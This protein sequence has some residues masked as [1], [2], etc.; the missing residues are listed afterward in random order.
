MATIKGCH[1]VGSVPL[2]DT[3]TV[4]KTCTQAMPNRLKRLPDGETGARQHFIACQGLL[5]PPAVQ[6]AF[7]LNKLPEF[8]DFSPE[9][10]DEGL[11]LL[12]KADMKTGYDDAAL[13]SYAVFRQLKQ[14]GVIPADVRFQVSLPALGSVVSVFVQKAFQPRAE[15]LYEAAMFDAM[16]NIQEGIPHG[17]LAIQ[18]D[19]AVDMFHWEGAWGDPWWGDREHLVGYVARM[20]DQVDKD[21]ELGFH[22]CYGEIILH[23]RGDDVGELTDVQLQATWTTGTSSNHSRSR[24]SP[25]SA[26]PSSTRPTARRPLCT[27]PCP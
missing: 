8:R 27:A 3:E 20:A 13:A 17:E 24:A 19:L 22:F 21:V 26:T 5:F 14:D 9:Q 23:K 6:C 10:V 25:T 16:R 11:R 2:A 15:Q 18:L 4:F 7:H 12:E 1:L